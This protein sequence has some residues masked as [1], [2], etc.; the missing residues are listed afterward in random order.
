MKTIFLATSNPYKLKELTDLFQLAKAPCCL[1][2]ANTIGGMPFVEETEIT[3]ESN[4]LLKAKAL[5]PKASGASWILA[6]DSGLCIESL[7]GDPG[8][9]SARYAQRPPISS[10]NCQKVL[11][12]MAKSKNPSRKAYLITSLVLLTEQKTIV[13]TEKCQ[14]NI[15]ESNHF[16]FQEGFGYDP[17]FIPEGYTQTFSQLGNAIKNKVSHRAC[18]CQA[19]IQWIQKQSL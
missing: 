12:E 19:L 1:K 8:I 14:G 4:A 15:L 3:F 2:D 7:G 10:S 17:I 9:Y 6:D 18:A 5:K 13:F 11:E 16:E